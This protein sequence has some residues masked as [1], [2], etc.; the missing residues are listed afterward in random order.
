MTYMRT[1][2]ACGMGDG[3]GEAY[4]DAF[5]QGNFE[6]PYSMVKRRISALRPPVSRMASEV[7]ALCLMVAGS[8]KPYVRR[9]RMAEG[10]H[11]FTLVNDA[12]LAHASF[13]KGFA[14]DA[15]FKTVTESTRKVMDGRWYLYN[16]IVP[17]T[18]ERLINVNVVVYRALMSS[19]SKAADEAVFDCFLEELAEAGCSITW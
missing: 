3:S 9:M 16:I 8:S 19:L 11:F 6:I 2:G 14:G 12:M 15:T 13:W 18:S 7:G 10:A 4:Y 1:N 5:F 17:A